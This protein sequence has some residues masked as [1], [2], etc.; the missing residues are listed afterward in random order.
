M[1]MVA[2]AVVV[3]VMAATHQETLE[4]LILASH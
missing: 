3:V 4:L 1:V 2:V